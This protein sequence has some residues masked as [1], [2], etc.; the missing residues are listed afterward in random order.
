MLVT[1]FLIVTNVYSSVDAPSK[2]GFSYIEQWYLCVLT[3][4]VLALLE[5]GILLTIAKLRGGFQGPMKVGT[6]K[7]N[8]DRLV[9]H[10]DIISFLFCL[11]IIVI[12]NLY[13][14]SQIK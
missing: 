3:P 6:S 2:R 4:I 13:Y 14:W 5:Y 9:V 1:L 7:I 12:L 10:V 8:F 11:L